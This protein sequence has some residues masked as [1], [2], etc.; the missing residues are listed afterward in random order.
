MKSKKKRIGILFYVAAAC[1]LIVCIH[2]FMESKV[3]L[4]AL[5]MCLASSNFCN[6]IM[7][8]NNCKRDDENDDENV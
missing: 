3:G 8:L 1:F 2:N 7:W 4:G 5:Y 6:G